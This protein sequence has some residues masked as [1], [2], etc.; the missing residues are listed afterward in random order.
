M[1]ETDKKRRNPRSKASLRAVLNRQS[2][3][4]HIIVVMVSTF[5]NKEVGI[6]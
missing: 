6:F 1:N 5:S 3:N 4:T 2:R